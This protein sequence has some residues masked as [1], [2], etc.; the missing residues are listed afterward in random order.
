MAR[1][2]CPLHV[3]QVVVFQVRS[4]R[5]E[6]RASVRWPRVAPLGLSILKQVSRKPGEHQPGPIFG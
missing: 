3:F 4:Y 1:S 5:P 6:A 2:R